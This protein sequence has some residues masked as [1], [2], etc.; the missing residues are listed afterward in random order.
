MLVHNIQFLPIY[1]SVCL[2]LF[3]SEIRLNLHI[4]NSSHG[5]NFATFSIFI[6]KKWNKTE[7]RSNYSCFYANNDMRVSDLDKILSCDFY[8]DCC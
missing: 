8:S 2:V 5:I 1:L 7:T 3:Q 4:W 6:R